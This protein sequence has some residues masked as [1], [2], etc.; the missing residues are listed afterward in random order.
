VKRPLSRLLNWPDPGGAP[1]LAP[2]NVSSL[3]AYL[4]TNVQNT[5]VSDHVGAGDSMTASGGGSQ[6][7]TD[8]AGLFVATDVNQRIRIAGGLAANNG[9][10]WVSARTANTITYANPTGVV[11]AA[12]AGAWTLPGKYSQLIDLKNARAFTQATDTNRLAATLFGSFLC[13]GKALT[14]TPVALSYANADVSAFE[15]VDVSVSVRAY[16]TNYGGASVLLAEICNGPPQTNSLRF[17]INAALPNTVLRLNWVDAG[18]VSLLSSPVA[19]L[20]LNTWFTLGWR[21]NRG[22]RTMTGYVNGA[23]IGTSA[24]GTARN[25]VGLN[26]VD[27]STRQFGQSATGI[28]FSGVAY[29]PV[30]WTDA[31]FLAVHNS[32]LAYN[33]PT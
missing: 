5:I 30:A 21:L 13:A 8:A 25:P 14:G 17:A 33:V 20:S 3:F 16:L 1:A 22:A 19:G 9:D 4:I 11:D 24:A 32:F 31:E 15:G 28:V 18:G 27:L 6:V 23:S 10:F 26:Q 2:P 12:Y 29:A 7:L